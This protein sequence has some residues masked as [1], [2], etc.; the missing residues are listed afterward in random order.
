[1]AKNSK[2]TSVKPGRFVLIIDRGWIFAGDQ[3]L[4]EDGYVRLDR[5]IHVF[6][7][8]KIGFAKMIQEWDSPNVDLRPAEPIEVPPDAVIFRVPVPQD[9]GCKD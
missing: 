8:Q 4:T 1:M 6:G 9:W 3:T 5:C 2:L 7:W